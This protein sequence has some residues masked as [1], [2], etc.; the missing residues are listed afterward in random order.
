MKRYKISYQEDKEIKNKIVDEK[1]IDFYKERFDILSIN[2]IKSNFMDKFKIKRQV[3]KKDLYLL[4]YE[5]NIMLESNINISDA[6][7]II[8]KS[9]KSRAIREFLDRIN[10]AFSNSSSINLALKDYKIDSYIKDFLENSQINSNLSS[11][12]K[13]IYLLLKEQEEIRKSFKKVLYYPFFLFFTF[14]TSLFIIFYFV[15]PSFKSIFHNQMETLPTSTKILLNFENFFLDYFFIISLLIFLV[16]FLFIS[17]YKINS[18]FQLFID[19]ISFKYLFVFSKILKNLEFY[20]LFLLIDI[21]QKSK[22]EFHKSFLDSKLLLKNKYLLD[23]IEL[24]DKLLTNGKSISFAFDKSEVFDD[25]I[26]NLL[27][28]GEVSNNLEV[29]VSEIKEIY[30]SRFD[31]SIKF[32]ISFISPFF[33]II[34]SSMILFL[35]LAIFTPIWQMGS[36]I[37]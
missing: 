10:Y 25:I 2:E 35:V 8:K 12:I 31:N 37:K 21:M 14:I 9:K 11:N 6:I 16:L 15:I 30:K 5:L 20:K 29:I 33:L 18:R 24:I 26:L 19:F 34:I 4:F 22:Y 1:E 13:A 36:L 28:T 23:R 3:S 17:I 27:N 7:L 32:M